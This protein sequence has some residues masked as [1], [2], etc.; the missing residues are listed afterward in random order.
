MKR[1]LFSL[2][3]P[4]MLALILIFWASA[5][6]SWIDNPLTV[7]AVS[8]TT[9]AIVQVLELVMERHAC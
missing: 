9:S 3:Q 6:A 8:I 1:T 2:L 4:A 5:P 7:T